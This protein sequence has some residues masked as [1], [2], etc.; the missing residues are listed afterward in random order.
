MVRPPVRRSR[1]FHPAEVPFGL[2]E[3]RSL[4]TTIVGMSHGRA[5]IPDTM[6]MPMTATHASEAHA[7]TEHKAHVGENKAHPIATTAHAAQDQTATHAARTKPVTHAAQDKTPT[8]TKVRAADVTIGDAHP[9]VEIDLATGLTYTS[10]EEA[11]SVYGGAMADPPPTPLQT[12]VDCIAS[13]AYAKTPDGAKILQ[14]IQDA[15]KNGKVKSQIL[16]P[17][18]RGTY[19]D[20]T[21]EITYNSMLDNDPGA[22]ASELVH[23]GAHILYDSRLPKP[24]L[25][26]IDEELYTNLQQ[27]AFYDG[28]TGASKPTTSYVNDELDRR[29]ALRDAGGDQLRNDVKMRYPDYK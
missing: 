14:N 3:P 18:L 2:L 5:V 24:A 4:L 15:I 8:G 27:L 21:G 11:D 22:I 19:N 1:A 23:E 6:A 26:N 28:Q 16:R 17:G 29:K 7:S 10:Q 12:A 13:S 25:D 20:G 9:N